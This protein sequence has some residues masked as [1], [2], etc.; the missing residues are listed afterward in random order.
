MYRRAACGR[1]VGCE[2]V[3]GQMRLCRESAEVVEY[4]QSWERYSDGWAL[5]KHEVE[6][7]K[8]VVERKRALRRFGRKTVVRA[9]ART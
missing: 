3:G 4:S 1:G 5:Y 9:D 7:K 2:D 8:G 6:R